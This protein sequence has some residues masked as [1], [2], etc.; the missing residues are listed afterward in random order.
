MI[1]TVLYLCLATG[2]C[3][4]NFTPL[5]PSELGCK[6]SKVTTLLAGRSSEED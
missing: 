2:N 3:F 6:P 1:E 4:E 5:V